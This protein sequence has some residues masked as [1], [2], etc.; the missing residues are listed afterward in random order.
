MDSLTMK[1]FTLEEANALVPEIRKI[2]MEINYEK[3]ELARKLIEAGDLKNRVNT[4]GNRAALKE[5]IEQII[6]LQE[7]LTESHRSLMEKGLIVRDL[8]QGIVDFP[9]IIEG[10][11]GYFCWKLGENKIDYWH[12]VGEGTR[13]LITGD[14]HLMHTSGS[15][16]NNGKTGRKQI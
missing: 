4:N 14:V 15:G 11:L 10:D 6:S 9:T 8:D 3:H 12:P 2:F 5:K 1:F 13:R 7:S 16:L